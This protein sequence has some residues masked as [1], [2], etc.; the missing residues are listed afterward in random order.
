MNIVFAGINIIQT[1]ENTK[2]GP[3][4]MYSSFDFNI[5]ILINNTIIEIIEA[6]KNAN[7]DISAILEYPK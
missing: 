1:A 2:N 5:I 4:G 7:N 6:I 3:K